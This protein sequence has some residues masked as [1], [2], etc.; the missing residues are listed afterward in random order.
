MAVCPF[1]LSSAYHFYHDPEM[2]YMIDSLGVFKG[3]LY[4]FCQHPGTPVALIGSFLFALTYPFLGPKNDFL[5][6]HLENP[7]LFMSITRGMLTIAHIVAA[8]LL[9]K[10]TIRVK[11]WVDA[12]FAVA[13]A[14]SFYVVSAFL[15][16]RSV[17]LWDHNSFN[18]P[19]GS[20]LLLGLFVTLTSEPIRGWRVLAIGCAAGVLTA[21]QVYF[22][23][24]VI[25]ILVTLGNFLPSSKAFVEANRTALLLY[26]IGLIA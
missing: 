8:I 24:W 12:L 17:I 13:V 21:A 11:R 25:G 2:A 10:H 9:I 1:H 4:D 15:G 7:E 14:A 5:M 6:H 16:F 19:F 20:L 18:M 23:T 3:E 22:L 26:R